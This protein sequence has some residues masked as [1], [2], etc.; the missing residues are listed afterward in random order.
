MARHSEKR[1]LLAEMVG[2]FILVFIGTG[3]VTMTKVAAAGHPF[4]VLEYL[5]IGTAFGVALMVAAYTVGPVSG[6]HLNPAVTIAL[7][8]ENRLEKGRVIP[9]ILAQCSGAILASLAL[10]A[11]LG[12][13]GHGLGETTV[14]AW[15]IQGALGAEGAL[16]ALLVFTVLGLTEKSAPPGFA[17]LIIGLYL[18]ASHLVGIPFSGNSLNPARSLGPAVILGGD[19]LRQLLPVYVVGPLVGALIGVAIYRWVKGEGLL[20]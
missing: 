6:A 4:G 15:G 20:S 17:G 1:D 2:T 11:L 9:Y 14:G 10:L 5:A 12:S 19:P 13:S 7:A 8:M 3:A 18:A 16:T